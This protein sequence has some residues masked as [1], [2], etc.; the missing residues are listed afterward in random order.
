[1]LKLPLRGVLAAVLLVALASPAVADTP[2]SPGPATDPVIVSSS[3]PGP[4]EPTSEAP[5]AAAS[6]ALAAANQVFDGASGPSPDAAT[7]EAAPDATVVLRDLAMRLPDLPTLRD[8]RAARR[9]LM[10][11]TDGDVSQTG[12][13]KYSVPAAATCSAAVC[14]HWV[15]NDANAPT[16]SDGD[17]TTVPG[18][19]STTLSTVDSVYTTETHTLGYRTPLA[20]TTAADNGGDG[21]LD[22]YLADIGDADIFGYCVPDD[23]A[24]ATSRSAF[25]YCVLDNDFAST[26]YGTAHTALQNL[27]V[28]SAHEIF[29]AVQFAYDW[30]EDLWLMEGTAAWV[31]DELFDAIDDNRRYLAVSPLAASDMPLDFASEQWDGYGSWAFWRFLSEWMASRGAVEDPTVVRQVWDA[32]AGSAYSTAALRHVLASRGTTLA[33]ALTVFGIWNRNPGRF[34]SEGRAYH[35]APLVAHRTFTRA[36]RTMRAHF[37]R[38][39]H[40]AQ[41]FVRFTPGT[42][43]RG[44]W[45]LQVAVA[46]PALSRGSHAWLVVHR[47]NGGIG[48]YPMRLNR[49]GDGVRTVGFDRRTTA[50][51]ELSLVNAST[52]FRCGQ[53]TYLSCAGAPLDDA[54][55]S[56]Y[57]A[58]VVR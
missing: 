43:L 4:T 13:P 42:S 10:R 58:R 21:R 29:H 3:S 38:L 28:T 15:E 7:P 57:A 8:R 54:L 31:E 48:A 22:V 36:S 45:R 17:P 19:V 1:V 30:T 44:R 37:T 56:G 40:L 49:S 33:E 39:H 50:Y 53:R 52:R 46:M 6:D 34:Y 2:A 47:R 9:I 25:G 18:W 23:P 12:E 35:A 41:R 20:D 32:A 26:Q 55:V 16:G 27:Q 5:A 14:V 11:P 24:Q 51:V